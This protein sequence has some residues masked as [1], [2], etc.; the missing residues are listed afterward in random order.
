VHL[1]GVLSAEEELNYPDFRAAERTFRLLLQVAGRAGRVGER[2]EVIVQTRIPEHPLFGY[3]VRG[4]VAGFLEE[5]LRARRDLAYPPF[6]RLILAILGGAKEETVEAVARRW[7]DA[8][9]ELW[10]GEPV[11]VLGP[12]LPLLPKLRGRH[13]RQILIKGRPTV[14]QKRR[15]LERFEA[16]RKAVRGGRA[17][18]LRWDVDPQSFF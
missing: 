1:V 11:T 2:G 6:G 13:R 3:L 18:E 8:L 12:G 7:A 14:E 16:C 4:D 10:S 5:E 9:R 17:V 15:A